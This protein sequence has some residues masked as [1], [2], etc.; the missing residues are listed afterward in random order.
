MPVAVGR[1]I[2]RMHDQIDTYRSR[3]NI[4]AL[5]G[6]ALTPVDMRRPFCRF[7]SIAIEPPYLPAPRCQRPDHR[8]ADT[9]G[10]AENKSNSGRFRLSHH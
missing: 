8:S 4:A 9:A 3:C 2:D 6:V 7:G 1:R 10:G 5:H